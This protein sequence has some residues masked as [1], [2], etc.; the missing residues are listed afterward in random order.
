MNIVLFNLVVDSIIIIGLVYT[1]LLFV[2]AILE[3]VREI[4]QKYKKMR[5]RKDG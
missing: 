1:L 2:K 5:K 3:L 4:E